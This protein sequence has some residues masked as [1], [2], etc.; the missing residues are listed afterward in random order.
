MSLTKAQRD[1]IYRFAYN[2]Y[3]KLDQTHGIEHLKRTIKL[4]TYLAKRE[5]ADLQISKLG[6]ILHQLHDAE[7]VESFLGKIKVDKNL[8]KQIVH[9]VY[10]SDRKNIHEAKTV[11]A[12][13]VYDADKLQVVGPFGIIREISYCKAPPRKWSFRESL[14]YTR[15]AEQKYFKTLQTKTARKMAKESHEYLSRFW[16]ILDKWDKA[17]FKV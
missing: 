6:A 17:D 4:A 7:L 8:I 2:H 1:E 15:A 14:K 13:I 16:R 11:E 10:C 3:K 12:K 9:C 5:E